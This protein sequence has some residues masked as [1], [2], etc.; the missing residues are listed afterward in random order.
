MLDLFCGD[1]S[2]GKR[3]GA[4]PLGAV[5]N[6]PAYSYRDHWKCEKHHLRAIRLSTYLNPAEE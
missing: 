1:T 4:G 6:G 3:C 5:G 2:E